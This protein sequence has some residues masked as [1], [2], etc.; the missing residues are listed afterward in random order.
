MK[1][2]NPHLIRPFLAAVFLVCGF[3]GCKRAPIPPPTPIP[4][5]SPVLR[6]SAPATDP[7]TLAEIEGEFLLGPGEK[8]VFSETFTRGSRFSRDRMV[9]QD[10]FAHGEK[11][12]NWQQL[13]YFF[14]RPLDVRAGEIV[15]YW[16]FRADRTLGGEEVTKLSMHLP[17]TDLP[18][19]GHP[20]PAHI[21][22]IIRPGSW[23]WLIVDP[24]WQLTHLAEMRMEPPVNL[25]PT[26]TTIEKFRVA[27]RW[28]GGDD[29]EVEPA[30]WNAATGQWQNFTEQYKPGNPPGILKL[31]IQKHL[32][33]HTGFRSLFFQPFSEIPHLD[34]VLVT[35]RP[36]P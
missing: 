16:G 36:G 24:G 19:V 7:E 2:I 27:V 28:L 22:F 23:S 29:V 26:A 6:T 5:P 35:F 4:P 12:E 15:I 1:S 17:F 13:T 33:G 10:G 11:G 25:F 9:V 18:T 20:E 31:S 14:D 3:V 8:P 32:L 34:S 30:C 21:S